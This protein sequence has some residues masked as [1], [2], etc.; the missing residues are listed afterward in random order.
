[1]RQQI[2]F[3]NDVCF[4]A[5]I[6]MEIDMQADSV[7]KSTATWF[8]CMFYQEFGELMLPQTHYLDCHERNIIS[9]L[10]SLEHIMSN[11]ML[12]L[13]DVLWIQCETEPSSKNP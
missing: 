3:P 1:M 10:L 7:M 11:N 13:V 8:Y 9:K 5:Y 4:I 6:K 2:Q 12:K